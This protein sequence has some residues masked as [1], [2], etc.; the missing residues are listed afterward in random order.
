MKDDAQCFTLQSDVTQRHAL[1]RSVRSS[2]NDYC[3]LNHDPLWLCSE[4]KSI[5]G[6]VKPNSAET[7]PVEAYRNCLR[8]SKE[9]VM[10]HVARHA[11]YMER[12]HICHQP[13]DTHT[14]TAPCTNTATRK[15]SDPDGEC[16]TSANGVRDD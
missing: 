6:A 9:I 1:I 8:K 3:S 5:R 15:R 11:A 12:R 14:T 7:R 2:A 16:M 10:A 4:I 13:V